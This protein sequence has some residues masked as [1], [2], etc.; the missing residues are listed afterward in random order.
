M[1]TTALF[2]KLKVL[3]FINRN[4]ELHPVHLVIFDLIIKH[5]FPI[6][7]YYFNWNCLT[8]LYFVQTIPVAELETFLAPYQVQP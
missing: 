6:G 1:N 7:K 4:I 5:M 2:I 3:S 8:E